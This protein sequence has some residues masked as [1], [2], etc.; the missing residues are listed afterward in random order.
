MAIQGN[1]IQVGGDDEVWGNEANYSAEG[2]E[3]SPVSPVI[4]IT[5][6]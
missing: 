4:S 5:F 1:I 6:Q 2:P 3:P